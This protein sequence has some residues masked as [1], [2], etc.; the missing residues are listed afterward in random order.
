MHLPRSELIARLRIL[1]RMDGP[2]I[3]IALSCKRS[4]PDVPAMP[5]GI[6]ITEDA[7]TEA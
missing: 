1:R 2:R 4:H 7:S 6:Q 5:V 3:S